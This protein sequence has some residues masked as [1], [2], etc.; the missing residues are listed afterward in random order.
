MPQLH[1]V[2]ASKSTIRPS[3]YSS[4]AAR[5]FMRARRQKDEQIRGWTLLKT[6]SGLKKALKCRKEVLLKT[7]LF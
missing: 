1:F 3:G 6:G 4:Q 7:F 5:R 2:T